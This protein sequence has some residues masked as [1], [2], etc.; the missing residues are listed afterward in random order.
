VSDPAT[1]A[2]VL[3]PAEPLA[4]PARPDPRGL[5]VALADYEPSGPVAPL[6]RRARRAAEHAVESPAPSFGP[7]AD[8]LPELVDIDDDW[9]EVPSCVRLVAGTESGAPA[10]KDAASK[11]AASKDAASKDAASKAPVRQAPGV[12]VP[13]APVPSRPGLLPDFPSLPSLPSLPTRP[14]LSGRTRP[15][16]PVDGSGPT[17]SSIPV[18]RPPVQ[19]R[20]PDDDATSATAETRSLRVTPPDAKALFRTPVGPKGADGAGA[21]SRG[22]PTASLPPAANVVPPT[23]AEAP[24]RPVAPKQ[25]IDG[26]LVLAES[27]SG[28]TRKVVIVPSIAVQQSAPPAESD[29]TVPRTAPQAARRDPRTAPDPAMAEWLG[30]LRGEEAPLAG[31]NRVDEFVVGDV[32]AAA[33][34]VPVRERDARQ[35]RKAEAKARKAEAKAR[36]AEAKM[37]RSSRRSRREEDRVVEAVPHGDDV[38]RYPDMD[39]LDSFE[40]G[41]LLSVVVFWAP[42]LILLLLAGV[43]IWLVR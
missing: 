42:A 41:R 6:S 11:D 33:T 21:P 20:R 8:E 22:T 37:A 14:D 1:V 25:Q 32:P 29:R 9:V 36:K 23:P 43:V 17:T 26:G 2:I 13:V 12:H 27:D 39:D 35:A 10:S 30:E 34:V 24:P 28:R 31:G 19:V 7:S 4:G 16:R 5:P 40:R 18:I 38:A 15:R 3:P